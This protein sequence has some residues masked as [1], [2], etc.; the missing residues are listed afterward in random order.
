MGKRTITAIGNKQ[1]TMSRQLRTKS[2]GLC[3]Q[4]AAV[5][6]RV[7]YQSDRQWIFVCLSC[8]EKV[9]ENNPF[10]LYGGTWKAKKK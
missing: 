10:Y 3:S 9:S 8:W 6:Y 5:L 7:Q 2:C 4:N 1:L